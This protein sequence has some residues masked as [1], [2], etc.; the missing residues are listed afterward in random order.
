MS[1]QPLRKPV[2]LLT[3]A[4]AG[5]GLIL[6]KLLM[7]KNYHLVLT[8]RSDSLGRFEKEGVREAEG[9]W[10]RA[11]DVMNDRDRKAVVS[12]INEKLGGVDIL[13]NNAGFAFRSVLEHVEQ[14]ELLQQM[15]TNFWGPME[16]VRLV[17]PKMRER[18]EGRIVNVSSVGGMMAMPTMAIYSAS[19]FALE[20]ASEALYYELKPWNIKVSLIEPGFIR[21][22]SFAKVRYTTLSGHSM[23]DP[24]E[25]YFGHYRFMSDFIGRLMH[26]TPATAQSVAQ[27]IEATIRKPNPPLRVLA[28]VDAR[29]FD[30]L[31]RLLPARFYHWLLYRG[32]PYPNCWGDEERLRRRCKLQRMN[33]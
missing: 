22:D 4:S 31:R 1:R 20:G 8:A 6:A 7:T 2:L 24:S 32:L 18:S 26:L 30:L 25:A 10:L 11:L 21:S 17:L 13:I 28:T 16:I 29:I 5:L 23:R 3:G 27:K 14:E 12:E 33:L 9:V 15:I 19:K